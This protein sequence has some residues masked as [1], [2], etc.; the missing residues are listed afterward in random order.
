MF[1][2]RNGN[3]HCILLEIDPWRA[4]RYRVWRQC[5]GSVTWVGRID[6]QALT[7]ELDSHDAQAPTD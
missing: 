7:R 5:D 2:D 1:E 3:S 6:S 4:D